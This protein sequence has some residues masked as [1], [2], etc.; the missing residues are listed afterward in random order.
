[1]TIGIH[2]KEVRFFM[3]HGTEIVSVVAR[4]IMSE[5]GHPGVEAK[6][7]TANG[8]KG[9]AICTAGVSIGTKEIP[10]AY[11]GGTKWRGKGVMKAVNAVNDVI[12]PL[13]KGMDA[14]KQ[15]EVDNA[16]LAY[17]GDGKAALGGNAT[18]AV[19]AAVLKAGAA[20]LDIPLYEHIGGARAYTL[21]VPGVICMGG[22]D[23]Y[24][25]NT[26]SG[27]KP[28]YS[29]MAYNFPTFSEAS[30]ACWEMS[31][32]WADVLNK[33][34]RVPKTGVTHIPLL[35]A[36][37][38]KHDRELWDLMAETICRAGYEG[39][40]G[41]QVDVAT[42]PYWEA[43]IKKYVGIFSAEPKT[44]EDIFELYLSMVKNYPF[45]IIE[46]PFDEDDYETTAKLTKA[47]DIQIVGDDL[48]TTNP[49]RVQQG[50]DAGAAN[51]VLLKVNQIGSIT[52][53]FDMIQLAYENGYGVMP[54]NSRGEGADIADY[55]VG[56]CC[57]SVRESGTGAVGNRFLEIEAELGARARFVGKKGL[58][59][60]RFQ[61]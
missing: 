61:S 15:I 2:S 24:S 58:K 25:P 59:G 1:M 12:A 6:V 21:P 27:G 10:F 48:F 17:K 49:R 46:D 50:I 23:R 33:Q 7:V 36:G 8:A 29:F 39:K 14:T 35:P 5:R 52:E 41:I 47:V 19:S 60:K 51:T 45:V 30:Y 34:F 4:E 42:E 55:C 9:V 43:D 54:C 44:K 26:R 13:I 56:I 40:V 53:S 32:E 11:D 57:G 16:M 38:I 31:V 22:S 20:A 3:A 28:S 18:A 37:L